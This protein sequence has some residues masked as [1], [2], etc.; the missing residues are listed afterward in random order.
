MSESS[1]PSFWT[2]V[3]GI[4]TAIAGIISAIAVLITAVVSLMGALPKP[5]S[6]AGPT[7]VASATASAANSTAATST[8]AASARSG[9]ASFTPAGPDGRI[10]F[11]SLRTDPVVG[12]QADLYAVDPTSL[13]EFRLTNDFKPDSYPVA[14]PD[15]TRIAFDS[16][17]TANQRDIWVLESNGT[18]TQLTNDAREDSLATW[19]PNGDQIAWVAGGPGAREIWVMSSRD[20][21]G[22]RR[23]SSGADDVSPS[24]S[25]NGLIAFQRKVGGAWEIWVVD[26][27]G[28]PRPRP[29]IAA[30]QGGGMQPAWSHD[31]TQLAFVRGVAGVARIFVVRAD[32]SGLRAVTPTA[33]CDCEHPT[34][35]PDGTQIAYMGPGTLSRP[36]MV[37]PAA[38][39]VPRKVD[40]NGLAPSWGR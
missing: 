29:L 37:V 27:F 22:A 21:S 12:P 36:V 11:Y 14:S 6:P 17:R 15:G 34:W 13:K 32:G 5:S 24:W 20:G 2:T 40:D 39:G 10:L 30:S 23:L 33:A 8:P 3:P 4:L 19:S 31:G 25:R 16:R 1:K 26:P 28:V 7:A 18:L 35:S 38:G 9:T